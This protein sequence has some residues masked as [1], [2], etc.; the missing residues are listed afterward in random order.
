MSF[1]LTAQAPY[2]TFSVVA[3]E[4]LT[5]TRPPRGRGEKRDQSSGPGVA[6]RDV[7]DEVRTRMARR[8]YFWE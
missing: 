1:P 7:I 6:C 4:R 3:E 8:G 5:A 2:P